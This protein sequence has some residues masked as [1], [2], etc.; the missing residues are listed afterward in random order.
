MY[1]IGKKTL[2]YLSVFKY[3]K[4]RSVEKCNIIFYLKEDL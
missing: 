1:K 4:H 2:I 3:L